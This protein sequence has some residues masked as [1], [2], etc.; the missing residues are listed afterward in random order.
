MIA[1]EVLLSVA[2]LA[3][4]VTD[5][6]SHCVAGWIDPGGAKRTAP[7][8]IDVNRTARLDAAVLPKRTS[9]IA[10]PRP[11]IIPLPADV[12]VVIEL[13]VSFGI[14]DEAGRALWISARDGRL[15]TTIDGGE[16]SSTE[17]AAVSHCSALAQARF[18]EALS[19]R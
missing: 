17:A 12:R 14:V 10:C 15:Q 1:S 11:S 7:I 4:G 16:L 6:Q 8:I 19:R 13:G 9:G 18:D 5:A 2:L 3:S